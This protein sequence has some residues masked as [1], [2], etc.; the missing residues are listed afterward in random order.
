MDPKQSIATGITLAVLANPIVTSPIVVGMFS[1]DYERKAAIVAGLE[2]EPTDEPHSPEREVPLGIEEGNQFVY[3]TVVTRT[4]IA[5]D[6][7]YY[8]Q[9]QRMSGN[10][11]NSQVFFD[12][13]EELPV[14]PAL[15]DSGYMPPQPQWPW[16]NKQSNIY[17]DF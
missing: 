1:A 9:D 13:N 12:G 3:E 10:S 15:D 11:L 14:S 16:W 6:D 4:P 5:L 8:F 17:A 7:A 2:Q